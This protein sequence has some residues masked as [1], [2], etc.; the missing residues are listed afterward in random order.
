LKVDYYLPSHS[1]KLFSK[2]LI[3][4]MIECI[5]KCEKKTFFEYDYPRPPYSKGFMRVY[6]LKDE[7]VGI[8]ISEE[9]NQRRIIE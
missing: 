5:E 4:T 7:P 9:E 2:D 8:I 1:D 6:S 3:T